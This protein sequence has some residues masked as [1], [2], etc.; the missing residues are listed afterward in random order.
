MNP[1]ILQKIPRKYTDKI[2]ILPAILTLGNAICGT[3]AILAALSL[4]FEKSAYYIVFSLILDALDGSISRLTKTAS[5]FGTQLDTLCDIISFGLAPAIISWVFLDVENYI[6]MSIQ[7][8][9]AIFYVCSAIIR[10]AR[11]NVETDVSIESHMFFKGLPS[12]GAA[13]FVIFNLLLLYKLLNIKTNMG[14]IQYLITVYKYLFPLIIITSAVLMVTRLRYIHIFNI[15]FSG[16]KSKKS[17]IK[18]V[19]LLFL[20]LLKPF[21]SIFLISWAFVLYPLY[22]RYITTLRKPQEEVAFKFKI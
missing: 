18:L 6:S 10:L 13:L 7:N 17:F 4:D 1:K 5:Q 3:F 15:S 21:V 2:F 20:I 8:S 19:I 12:P 22:S 9:I 14:I 11:F 16:K